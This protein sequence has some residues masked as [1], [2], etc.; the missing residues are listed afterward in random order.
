MQISPRDRV[1]V[2]RSQSQCCIIAQKM[3]M[4]FMSFLAKFRC[5][6]FITS[7]AGPWFQHGGLVGKKVPLHGKKPCCLKVAVWFLANKFGRAV[8]CVLIEGQ[9]ISCF[10][11]TFTNVRFTTSLFYDMSRHSS[12]R[13]L[14]ET[15]C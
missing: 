11:A 6:C 8:F 4:V 5:E 1:K 9:M 10:E 3:V 2:T 12:P 14:R 15:A 13:S 7:A